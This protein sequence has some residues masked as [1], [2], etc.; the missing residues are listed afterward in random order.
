MLRR[1]PFISCHWEVWSERELK[2]VVSV[3]SDRAAVKRESNTVVNWLF[4][5][6]D[7][8]LIL[9]L[10]S[11]VDVIFAVVESNSFDFDAIL[12]IVEDVTPD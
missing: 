8:V 6:L 11:V 2:I 7:T 12:F 9:S 5:S 10:V 3:W 1:R 4:S